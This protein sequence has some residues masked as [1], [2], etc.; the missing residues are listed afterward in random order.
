[1][2]LGVLIGLIFVVWNLYQSGSLSPNVIEDYRVGYPVTAVFFFV[3]IYALT[4]C[5]CL[6]SLPL[7]L[8]AGFFWGGLFGGIYSAL[9]VTLGGWAAFAFAR[10][11]VGQ[12]FNTRF[13]N[14]LLETVRREFASGGW[15]FVAF[16]RINPIIPSGPFNYLLGLTSLSARSFVF[17]TM[18][19]LLPPSVAVA[20]IGDTFRTFS[21]QQSEVREVVSGLLIISA[22]VTFLF[23]LKI[24]VGLFKKM[25]GINK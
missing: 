21:A 14:K 17:L 24:V 16:A 11:L 25:N 7:N 5:A 19:F 15:K 9:A 23:G 10:G 22:S 8:A 3:L 13:D 18:I 20:Y 1:M 2:I 4:V 12:P 6:P